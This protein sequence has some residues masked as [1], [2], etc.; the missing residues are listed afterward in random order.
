MVTLKIYDIL[1]NEIT[2]LVNEEKPAGSYQVK[3]D[4]TGIPSGVYFYKLKV[5][6]PSTGSGQGFTQTKKM[7]LMK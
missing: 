7:I 2:T 6:D 1:G 5:G 4:A 3:F